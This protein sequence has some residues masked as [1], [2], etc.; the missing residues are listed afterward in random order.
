[1]KP[2]TLFTILS[3]FLAVA[4]LVGTAITAWHSRKTR[5]ERAAALQK[6]REESDRIEQDKD[7]IAVEAAQYAVA[8]LRS[9]LEA[10]KGDVRAAK[11]TIAAQDKI[12]QRQGDEIAALRAWA[13]IAKVRITEAGIDGLPEVPDTPRDPGSR[14]IPARRM[15]T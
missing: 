1:M 7:K 10:S 9:E 5:E 8:I 2:D 11:V 12:I 3:G 4:A 15:G 6:V 13:R 14:I